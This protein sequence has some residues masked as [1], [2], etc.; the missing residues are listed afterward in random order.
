MENLTPCAGGSSGVTFSVFGQFG[1]HKSILLCPRS[2]VEWVQISRCNQ[3]RGRGMSTLRDPQKIQSSA[4]RVVQYFLYFGIGYAT[5]WGGI[6]FLPC[7]SALFLFFSL[8]FSIA[9]LHWSHSP[10]ILF[11]LMASPIP[12]F[13]KWFSVDSCQVPNWENKFAAAYV[14]SKSFTDFLVVPC[15]I[16]SDSPRNT[17]W[18]HSSSRKP[19]SST[20]LVEA[21]LWPWKK[22]CLCPSNR[23]FSDFEVVPCRIYSDSLR[24]ELRPDSCSGKTWKLAFFNELGWQLFGTAKVNLPLPKLLEFQF[25]FWW[26]LVEPIQ[27]VSRTSNDWMLAPVSLF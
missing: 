22:K 8:Y 3:L 17:P 11:L 23:S 1:L 2:K 13:S 6:L 7:F 16:H 20:H 12:Q 9:L 18:L 26:I 10:S 19:S 4:D 27:M 5:I 25:F 14:S 15:R 21:C 24:N